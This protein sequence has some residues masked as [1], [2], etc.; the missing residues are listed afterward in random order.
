KEKEPSVFRKGGTRSL[1]DF[2]GA[3]RHGRQLE[4]AEA[5]PLSLGCSLPTPLHRPIFVVGEQN[6]AGSSQPH[7]CSDDIYSRGHVRRKDQ[8]FWIPSQKVSQL[9]PRLP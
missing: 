4:R 1:D 7:T 5:E 8:P 2:R 6:I 3:F 9:L